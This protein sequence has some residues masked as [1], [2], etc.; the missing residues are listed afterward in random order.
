MNYHKRKR[1][2]NELARIETIERKRIA[3]E[4]LGLGLQAIN[5]DHEEALQINQILD[6]EKTAS[7]E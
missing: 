1:V 4:V 5:E 2:A 6:E 7:E 3:N